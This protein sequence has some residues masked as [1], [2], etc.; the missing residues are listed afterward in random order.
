MRQ[1]VFS[2]SRQLLFPLAV[3]TF[4]L[5]GAGGLFPS[6]ADAQEQ[7]GILSLTVVPPA[8][9]ADG[10]THNA[11]FLQALRPDGSP[12]QPTRVVSVL[13]TSSNPSVASVPSQAELKPGSS[14]V[15]LPVRLSLS[16][17][18]T[19][20]SAA[21]F[22]YEGTSVE[23]RT[24]AAL[25]AEPLKRLTISA[26]PPTLYIGAKGIITVA[27]VDN[28]GVPYLSPTD[29]T[30]LLTSDSPRVVA[31]AKSILIPQDSYWARTEWVA[32]AIGS[33][34][35]LAQADGV[36]ADGARV[37]VVEKGGQPTHLE[38]F[39][40]LPTLIAREERQEA[41]VLQ[42]T[43][44]DRKPVSFPCVS[45]T[46][47]SSAPQTVSVT[48]ESTPPCEIS[49]SYVL[50]EV[51]TSWA[52]GSAQVTVA[53]P[54]MT[55]ATVRVA[56]QGRE[57][58]RLEVHIG[59]AKPL[60][61]DPNPVTLALQVVDSTG[62]PVVLHPEYRVTLLV[63][64]APGLVELTIPPGE[65][66][67]VLAP[68][69]TPDEGPLAVIATAPGL[70]GSNLSFGVTYLSL[71]AS[72]QASRELLQAGE[73]FTI[74]ARVTSQGKVV[75]GARV[76]WD[77]LDVPGA[78]SDTETDA[79]GHARLSLMPKQDGSVTIKVTASAPGYSSASATYTATVRS[80]SAEGQTSMSPFLVLGFLVSLILAGYLTYAFWPRHKPR[81]E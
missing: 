64:S 23:L 52:P 6:A 81:Q 61:A 24:N 41:L 14:Y 12:F 17:G 21:S 59:P 76:Q 67:V 40:T 75:A 2:L 1:G 10:Q 18:T 49:P 71:E 80:A 37:Q 34:G 5:A 46:I 30:V 42:A 39:P 70:E 79:E 16:P 13:L 78:A 57:A 43:D 25:G 11:L 27:L 29:V 47:T 63:S 60:A 9:P 4:L 55:S 53:T 38:V 22:G 20:I 51:N 72:L 44:A 77:A 19:R 3:G 35:V 74:T 73:E 8:L 62:R 33:A 7:A 54:G 45:L 65:S 31:L 26:L 50:Q 32:Q 58:R 69:A 48:R 36:E 66:F 28:G 15:V 68:V 56:T